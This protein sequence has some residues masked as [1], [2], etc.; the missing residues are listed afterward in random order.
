MP[1]LAVCK[2]A[3]LAGGME[4]IT[5]DAGGGFDAYLLKAFGLMMKL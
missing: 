5:V 1:P 2:D 4:E 3:G